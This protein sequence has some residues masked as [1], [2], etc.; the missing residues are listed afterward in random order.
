MK[1]KDDNSSSGASSVNKGG[2]NEADKGEFDLFWADQLAGKIANREKYRYVDR[3][4]EK[5][6]EFVVKTSAS[7]SGVLHIGRLSDTVRGATVYRALVD[8][9][10]KARFIWVAEDM[11]P[12]RKIPAGVPA[13]YEKYI[14]TAV[15]TLPDVDG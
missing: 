13:S 14:G 11:D 1:H 10:E 4:V 7:I 6:K 15:S 3:K 5:P 8:A 2:K 12:L 9:G